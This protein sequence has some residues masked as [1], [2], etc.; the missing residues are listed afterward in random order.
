M[1]TLLLVVVCALAGCVSGKFRDGVVVPAVAEDAPAVRQYAEWGVDA[2]PEG[3]REAARVKV[4]AFFAAAATGDRAVML[5]E[6]CPLRRE[7][8]ELCRAGIL[9]RIEGGEANPNARLLL[10]DVEEYGRMVTSACGGR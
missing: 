2:L 5:V 4:Q 3:Q 6:A 1:K 8:M 10:W 9:A 7:V